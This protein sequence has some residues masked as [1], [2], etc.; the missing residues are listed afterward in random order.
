MQEE[1]IEVTDEMI[2]AAKTAKSEDPKLPRKSP[3]RSGQEEY[4]ASSRNSARSDP[5]SRPPALLQIGAR[6]VNKDRNRK[7]VLANPADDETGCMKYEQLGY[8]YEV[9]HPKGVHIANGKKAKHGQNIEF[10]GSFLMSIS[11]QEFEDRMEYGDGISAGAAAHRSRIERIYNLGGAPKVSAG[12]ENAPP[13]N[14]APKT[15][16]YFSYEGVVSDG[17]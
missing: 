17:R 3:R 11:L 5:A 6:V 9:V 16:P 4:S 15:Q 10:Y 13:S 7:Y 1:N 2:E 14:G 12:S 8:R